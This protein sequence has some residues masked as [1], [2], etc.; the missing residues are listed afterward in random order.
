VV[1]DGWM[2][3]FLIELA[4]ARERTTGSVGRVGSCVFV[5]K[6]ADT[7]KSPVVKPRVR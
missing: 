4:R 7:F 6:W 1:V 3:V 2:A 5:W